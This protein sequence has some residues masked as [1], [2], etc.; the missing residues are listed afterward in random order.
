M[1]YIF[2]F[3]I[4]F[5][6]VI[7]YIDESKNVIASLLL[8]PRSLLVFKDDA[9]NCYKH[10]IQSKTEDNIDELI[11][12]KHLISYPT[13]SIV[14]RGNLRYSLTLRTVVKV[15]ED[16]ILATTLEKEEYL[17]KESF[18]YRSITE[19]SL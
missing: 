12:N 7:E 6:A 16:E 8:E 4:F 13:G 19:T 14:P 18:F 3:N 9:Y 5:S 17:R 10:Q 15:L 11:L 1:I 2:L